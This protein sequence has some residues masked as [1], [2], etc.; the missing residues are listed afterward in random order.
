LLLVKG[1][2]YVNH[3]AYNINLYSAYGQVFTRL[4]D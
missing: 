4:G 2:K 1:K 3:V